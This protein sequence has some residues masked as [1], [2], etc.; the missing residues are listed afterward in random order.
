[1][2]LKD[3]WRRRV[4]RLEGTSPRLH[5]FLASPESPYPVLREVAAFAIVLALGAAI[6]WGSMGQPL[7]DSPVVVVES[8]SMMH[9]ANGVGPQGNACESERY[10][11]IGTIDP[12]DLVFVKDIDRPSDVG[13]KAGKDSR[14]YGRAGD[15]VVYQPDGDSRRTPIIHRALFWLQINGQSETFTIEELG[16]HEVTTLNVPALQAL[17]LQLGYAEALRSMEAGPEDSGF[18]TRG[19]NNIEADQGPH[20]N[21]ARLP[22]KAEWIL[23]KARGEVPWLGL[24]KLKFSDW[25]VGTQNYRNAPSDSKTMLLLSLALL[26]GGPYVVERIARTRRER[27]AAAQ[28]ETAAPD[29]KVP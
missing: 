23:G 17:G 10:G 22:V 3:A 7:G 25:T 13:T 6:L 14:H 2:G 27:R 11:R 21:I 26:L 5:R 4:A 19:D 29:E 20:S 18:I 8:G 16:L 12:G 15:V 28:G 24:V 9:C 1:V